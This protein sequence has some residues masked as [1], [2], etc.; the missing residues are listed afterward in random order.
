[1]FGCPVKITSIPTDR[2]STRL[3][4]SHHFISYA[5]FCLKKKRSPLRMAYL[6]SQYPAVNHVFMLREVCFLRQLGFDIQVASIR[7]P[8]RDPGLI[9]PAEQAGARSTYYVKS[10]GLRRLLLAH[11]HTLVSRPVPYIRGLAGALRN[12]SERRPQA[13]YGLFYFTEAVAVGYWMRRQGL[14]HVHT[15]YA[16]TVGLA[17]ARI[18]PV[19]ISVTFH[20]S[21]EFLNPAGSRLAEKIHASLF[22]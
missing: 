20:G 4:S 11:V 9:T 10:A 12:S 19:T 2:K 18:F 16:S 7:N 17:V 6:L 21:A 5:V 14:T 22:C 13:L 8:D 15:Q 1:M 3:N